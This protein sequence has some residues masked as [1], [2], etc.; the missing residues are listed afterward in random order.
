ADI[1]LKASQQSLVVEGI[2]ESGKSPQIIL[3][4]S[5]PFATSY[6]TSVLQDLFIHHAQIT[7]STQNRQVTLIEKEID[8]LP[9]ILLYYYE[10]QDT[11][12]LKEMAEY[13][14]QWKIQTKQKKLEATTTTPRRGFVLDSIWWEPT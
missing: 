9:G 14:S 4:H 8:T 3:T 2:I 5:L 13:T 1:Q 11:Q 7:V 12:H 6:D 10:P